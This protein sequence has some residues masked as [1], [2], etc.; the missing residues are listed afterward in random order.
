[1]GLV[2]GSIKRLVWQCMSLVVATIL[3]ISCG[4]P[5]SLRSLSNGERGGQNAN[6]N[7][8]LS[9]LGAPTG[10]HQEIPQG[11]PKKADNAPE[12]AGYEPVTVTGDYKEKPSPPTEST[13]T[14]MHNGIELDE[15]GNPVY[16]SMPFYC[17]FRRYPSNIV[18]SLPKCKPFLHLIPRPEASPLTHGEGLS[19]DGIFRGRGSFDSYD[20]PFAANGGPLNGPFE[21]APCLGYGCYDGDYE[22]EDDDDDDQIK[23]GS[24]YLTDQ[25]NGGYPFADDDHRVYRGEQAIKKVTPQ[26][27]RF[28]LV[29]RA[30]DDDNGNGNHGPA[31]RHPNVTIKQ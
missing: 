4:M 5:K 12:D 30:D 6:E 8:A 19:F 31:A 22:D 29:H 25:H 11:I 26:T 1:M 3:G 20:G 13:S 17:D 18:L 14:S 16:K 27:Q 21:A 2:M 9:S 10:P 7:S 15:N 23:F 24:R 28:G